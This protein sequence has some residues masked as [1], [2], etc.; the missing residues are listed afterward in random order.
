LAPKSQIKRLGA[1]YNKALKVVSRVWKFANP[2]ALHALTGVPPADLL[3]LKHTLKYFIRSASY[4]LSTKSASQFTWHSVFKRVQMPLLQEAVGPF[5]NKTSIPRGDLSVVPIFAPWEAPPISI[6]FRLSENF[7]K[8]VILKNPISALKCKS[9]A[10]EII[11]KFPGAVIYTDG[12]KQDDH[13]GYGVYCR[14]WQISKSIRISNGANVF[15]AEAAAISTAINLAVDKGASPALIASDSLSVLK[16]LENL[17]PSPEINKIVQQLIVASNLGI[18]IEFLWIP[19]HIGIGG[20][21][22]ADR[23]A[24]E[25]LR[26]DDNLVEPI[27]LSIRTAYTA[28]NE[29][30]RKLWHQKW[31]GSGHPLART[32]TQPD[33]K[34]IV[35]HENYFLNSVLLSMAL[36]SPSLNFY[37]AKVTKGDPNCSC[38]LE[39]ENIDHFLFRCPLYLQQRPTLSNAM[40]EKKL[41]ASFSMRWLN[42]APLEV[43]KYISATGRWNR[44]A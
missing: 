41:P 36:N 27:P 14:A 23:L 8:T 33:F 22:M 1:V 5:L 10:L 35:F 39:E 38:G 18:Q 37:L 13:A 19:S 9:D 20:N 15:T 26:A 44:R 12:S 24:K 3:A 7:S 31:Q 30:I 42:E 4:S 40:R 21:E 17:S 2:Q 32:L 25:A 28:V 29:H 43:A 6:D 11:G 34:A 16:A